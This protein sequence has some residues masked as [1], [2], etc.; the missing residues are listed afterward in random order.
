MQRLFLTGGGGM[1]GQNIQA[2]ER[3]KDWEILA[4]TSTELD[5]TN[6]KAV[7]AYM[8]M[9]KP[10]LVVHAAGRVGGIQANIAHPVG[11]LDINNVIGRNVIMGAWSEGVQN[12]INLGST[13]TVSYTHLTL[14][15]TPYV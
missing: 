2:H 7:S 6:P 13:C 8:K 9:H 4:P 3:A 14:P 5:L 10:D 1:V 12:L 11:F 15:T